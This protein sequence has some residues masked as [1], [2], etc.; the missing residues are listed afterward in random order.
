[1]AAYNLQEILILYNK[2]SV[3][4]KISLTQS[5]IIR[6]VIEMISIPPIKIFR[7]LI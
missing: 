6:L 5:M 7:L 3:I 4:H 2:N 1:M